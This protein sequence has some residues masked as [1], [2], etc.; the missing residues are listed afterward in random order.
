MAACLVNS[1]KPVIPRYSLSNLAATMSCSACDRMRNICKA[2]NMI[3]QLVSSMRG[4]VGLSDRGETDDVNR[5]KWFHPANVSYLHSHVLHKGVHSLYELT[6]TRM[7]SH[8]HHGKHPLPSSSSGD[9][10]PLW[11]LQWH[12]IISIYSGETHDCLRQYRQRGMKLSSTN[13]V[14]NEKT[15]QG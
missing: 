2:V 6:V 11:K 1:G 7:V 9:L 3:L 10:Y 14:G 8:S 5:L 15:Y 12:L 13:R 4:H